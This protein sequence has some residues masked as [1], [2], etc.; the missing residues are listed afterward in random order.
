M[1]HSMPVRDFSHAKRAAQVPPLAHIQSENAHKERITIR[2]DADILAWFR[3][4]VSG[5]GNYQTLINNALRS[6][7]E[8]QGGALERILR[9]VLREELQQTA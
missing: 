6:H 8:E 3:A 9:R 2:L 5:G 1:K 7:I 4:Q